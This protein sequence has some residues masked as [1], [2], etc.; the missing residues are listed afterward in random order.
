[1]LIKQSYTATYRL[2]NPSFTCLC[3]PVQEGKTGKQNIQH[4]NNKWYL[5]ANKKGTELK[6]KCSGALPYEG[7]MTKPP[8]ELFYCHLSS[9][10]SSAYMGTI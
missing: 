3:W 8:L 9:F 7:I 6:S 4:Y 10:H 2:Q 1:M 5:T